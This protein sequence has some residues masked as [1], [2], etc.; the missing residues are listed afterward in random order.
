MKMTAKK[1]IRHQVLDSIRKMGIS[2]KWWPKRENKNRKEITPQQMVAIIASI[3]I[4]LIALG[5]LSLVYKVFG[6]PG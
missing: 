4:I 3:V 5:G 6:E 2:K 1:E